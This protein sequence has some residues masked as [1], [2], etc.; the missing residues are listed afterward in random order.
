M[1]NL[2]ITSYS[3]VIAFR[4]FNIFSQYFSIVSISTRKNFYK[5]KF[6]FQRF[7]IDF[8]LKTKQNK[9][10]EEIHEKLDQLD[11]TGALYSSELH[12]SDES[13]DGSEAKPFKTAL[14]V[15]LNLQVNSHL[16][17]I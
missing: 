17:F 12:G 4:N 9:M 7:I 2:Y 1:L 5:L 14:K 8:K 10:S 3:N 15:T 13:G 16:N 11:L 6:F